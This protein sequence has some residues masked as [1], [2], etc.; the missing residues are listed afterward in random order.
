MNQQTTEL[1]VWPASKWH[2][3]SLPRN[4]ML[5]LVWF[6]KRLYFINNGINCLSNGKGLESQKLLSARLEP[7]CFQ[8]FVP[9]KCCPTPHGNLRSRQNKDYKETYTSIAYLRKWLRATV[10]HRYTCC[11]NSMEF[12][13]YLFQ[14]KIAINPNHCTIKYIIISRLVAFW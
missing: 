1:L 13:Y 6:V 10:L 14:Y 3:Y 8:I 12:R 7:F 11:L 2:K 4:T 5:L 9:L